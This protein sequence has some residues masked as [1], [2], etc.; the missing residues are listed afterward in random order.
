MNIS[1]FLKP[2][3]DVAYIHDSDTLRQGMEKLR[4]YGYTAI[5]VLSDDDRY[6]GTITE[7][8]FL[9]SIVDFNSQQLHEVSARSLEDTSIAEMDFKWDY[10]S[11][12]INTSIE[13]LIDKAMMQNFVPVVDDRGAFIGIVTRQEIIK[14]FMEKNRKLQVV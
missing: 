8:D 6:M 9:W 11:V 12:H 5:P 7:G 2:K 1:F 10:P 14:H 3:S 4:Y 13:E